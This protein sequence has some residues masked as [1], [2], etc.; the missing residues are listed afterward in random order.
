MQI[1]IQQKP[2]PKQLEDPD[3]REQPLPPKQWHHK[4]I[5]KRTASISVEPTL[6]SNA[7]EAYDD[8]TNLDN[9][10]SDYDELLSCSFYHARCTLEQPNK[11]RASIMQLLP[12]KVHTRTAEQIRR[13]FHQSQWLRLSLFESRLPIMAN[14]QSCMHANWTI[15]S[16]PSSTSPTYTA[17]QSSKYEDK[18]IGSDKIFNHTVRETKRWV[19]DKI[20]NHIKTG[21]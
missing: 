4:N 12:C 9:E 11:R 3:L 20:F 2:H 13:N 1:Q 5:S 18:L 6:L 15:T 7:N 17:F 19:C 21:E 16:N 10:V 14:L 8:L